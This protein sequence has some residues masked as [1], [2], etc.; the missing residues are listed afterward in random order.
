MLRVR[1]EPM[2][3]RIMAEQDGGMSGYLRRLIVADLQARGILDKNGKPT[4]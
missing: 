1:I 4:C 3:Q 2:L